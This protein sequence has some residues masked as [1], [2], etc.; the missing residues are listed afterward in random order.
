MADL[1][2]TVSV[3]SGARDITLAEDYIAWNLF[4]GCS[5]VGFATVTK[6]DQPL[7][8]VLCASGYG[9]QIRPVLFR[10]ADLFLG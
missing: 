3:R 2:A 10:L 7:I 1:G 5:Q 9:P 6:D 8:C 4:N